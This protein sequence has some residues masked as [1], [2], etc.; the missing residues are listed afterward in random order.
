MP[1]VARL[2]ALGAVA[3][4][5]PAM[6]LVAIVLFVRDT[7]D[8]YAIAGAV[9]AAYTIGYAVAAPVQGRMADHYGP[10][11]VLWPLAIGHAIAIV[12]LIA[13]GLAGRSDVLLI[14][15]GLA[16]GLVMPPTGPV[17]RRALAQQAAKRRDL[18]PSVFALDSLVI[19]A[20][21]MGG[22]VLTAA[23]I[24]VASPAAALIVACVVAI[25][26][27][28]GLVVV[29]AIDVDESVRRSG[30]LG[31]LRSPGM[32]TLI[33]CLA[34]LGVAFGGFQVGMVAFAD[35][36]GASASAPWLLALLSL[37]GAIGAL[38]Y[39]A[40]GHR[41]ASSMALAC[42]AVL[43]PICF[44]PMILATSVLQMAFLVVL[45]GACLTP[46]I[47]ITNQIVGDVAP[48]DAVTEAYS[49]V[50]MAMLTGVAIGLAVGGKLVEAGNWHL[51][52]LLAIGATI[53]VAIVAVSRRRTL[54]DG[55]W[56]NPVPEAT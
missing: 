28:A 3:R 34:P 55:G 19:E 44:A 42:L 40:L 37:G 52:I 6:E 45:G 30:R 9:T 38:V 13:A 20:V 27:V 33:G 17:V 14:L 23:L 11:R 50:F 36:V 2:L 47:S 15:I 18:L 4:L 24:V 54:P 48:P 21:F 39:G 10:A 8:S 46:V 25:V 12:A 7:S 51:G 22:P 29:P 49:W 16:C 32:R 53:T 56:H 41:F 43:A 35:D 31:A 26:A 1:H 5:S